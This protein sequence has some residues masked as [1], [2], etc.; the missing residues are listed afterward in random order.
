MKIDSTVKK[1]YSFETHSGGLIFQIPIEAFPDLWTYAY[2]VLDKNYTVLIDTGSG[3]GAAA[4]Q[5]VEGIH[6]AGKLGRGDKFSIEDL[7]HVLITHGHIDHFGGLKEI[8]RRTGALI[9]VH[10]LDRRNIINYMER[11]T[12]QLYLL[13]DYL[14]Q[15]GVNGEKRESLIDFYRLTMRLFDSADVDFGF[16]KIKMQLGPFQFLHVPG[17]SGGHVVIRFDDV[18]FC[19]DHILSDITPHQTPEQLSPW[20]GL[21]H[22]LGSLD[23]LD[24]WAGEVQYALCGHNDVIYDMH[25]RISEIKQMH[26][27]R[28]EL[29]LSFLHSANTINALSDYLFGNMFGLDGLLAIEEAGAHVEYLYQRGLL[30]IK[31]YDRLDNITGPVELQYQADFKDHYS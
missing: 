6:Q 9:G 30:T 25:A 21:N 14:I 1:P 16:E 19:G 15:A 8:K 4:E 7:T 18:L 24:Q 20:S 22:Y 12:V 27:Q 17:H 28:L 23:L 26:H 29:V 5:L 13:T 11:R 2:L 31:N 3:V 10:E